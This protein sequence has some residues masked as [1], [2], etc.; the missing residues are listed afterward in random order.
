MDGLVQKR[1][2]SFVPR[3]SRDTPGHQDRARCWPVGD[4]GQKILKTLRGPRSRNSK[5]SNG[6][7]GSG[8]SGKNDATTSTENG[9]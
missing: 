5:G 8:S 2:V 6:G 9:I 1:N 7:P 3:V 4:G